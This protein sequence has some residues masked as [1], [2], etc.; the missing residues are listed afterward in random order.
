M[1]KFLLILTLLA[2]SFALAQ[3][4]TPKP[5]AYLEQM[6]ANLAGQ[7][8]QLQA[9]NAALQA[10]LAEVEAKSKAKTDAK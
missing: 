6:I 8:A 10:K 9:A 3:T 5:E 1:K 2:P 4:Q 7:V